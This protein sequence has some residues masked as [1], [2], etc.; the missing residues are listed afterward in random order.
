MASANS[1]GFML[2]T[3]RTDI[4][5]WCICRLQEHGKGWRTIMDTCTRSSRRST[6]AMT[7]DG[8]DCIMWFAGMA[9][10]QSMAG[11]SRRG[12]MLHTFEAEGADELSVEQN[13]QVTVLGDEIDGWFNVV[14]AAGDQGIVPS[15]YV[16][17]LDSF[18][19]GYHRRVHLP[20]PP[21]RAQVPLKCPGPQHLPTLS[22]QR[23]LAE[24]IILL[25]CSKQSGRSER[26][27][28]DQR[29]HATFL[30]ADPGRLRRMA[31]GVQCA[32]LACSSALML[33][34]HA[35]AMPG[36]QPACC[37]QLQCFGSLANCLMAGFAHPPP[38]P[39]L[40]HP[41][42]CYLLDH[43]IIQPALHMRDEISVS[44]Q[45]MLGHKALSSKATR[46]FESA[47]KVL[48]QCLQ[49]SY[50]IS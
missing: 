11:A 14:S 44:L 23:Y 15:S 31:A 45:N 36:F 10:A 24:Q 35:Q 18:E 25:Q 43:C 50:R 42:T 49:Q 16:Q 32:M 2:H 22:W 33:M 40:A 12:F 5:C 47:I 30:K 29:R 28:E 19:T 27:C 17:I 9:R 3:F 34:M 26:R 7:P 13:E 8:E 6:P 37:L 1:Q 41:C 4:N 21:Q 46:R 39:G 20:L 48:A 38:L